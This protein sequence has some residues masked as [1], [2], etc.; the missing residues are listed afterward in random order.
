MSRE[1]FILIK[2]IVPTVQDTLKV[3]MANSDQA[4]TELGEVKLVKITRVFATNGCGW[5]EMLQERRKQCNNAPNFM[6]FH[7]EE[8]FAYCGEAR[9]SDT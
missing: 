6:E 2:W 8:L 5:N 3:E 4:L 7:L 9:L 1:G